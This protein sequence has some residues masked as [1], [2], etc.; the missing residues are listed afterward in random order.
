MQS[1]QKAYLLD[2]EENERENGITVDCAK[3]MLELE[4]RRLTIIDAPGHV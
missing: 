4:D 2:T 1:F 3:I